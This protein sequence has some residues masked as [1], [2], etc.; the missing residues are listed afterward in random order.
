MSLWQLCQ[1]WGPKGLVISTCP[2]TK[3]KCFINQNSIKTQRVFSSFCE[4]FKNYVPRVDTPSVNILFNKHLC[5]K[6]EMMKIQVSI[7]YLQ[8]HSWE[9]YLKSFITIRLPFS[10]YY[11]IL[12][13]FPVNLHISMLKDN[14]SY[15]Q[16]RL[17]TSQ[18]GLR[19]HLEWECKDSRVISATL[20][21]KFPFDFGNSYINFTK[22]YW[23]HHCHLISKY[24]RHQVPSIGEGSGP[25]FS[26]FI[27]TPL[28]TFCTSD[29][30]HWFSILGE[31]T[32]YDRPRTE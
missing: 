12:L 18:N 32:Q 3:K 26:K 27:T 21:F 8:N 7:E 15:T 31:H 17:G 29:S 10:Y 5:K 25:A 11:N 1:G 28:C 19:L 14:I 2:S 9:S 6:V 22:L 13:L 4:E 30:R 20:N 24:K 16:L 23:H